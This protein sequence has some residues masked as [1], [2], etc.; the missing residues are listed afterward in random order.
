MH[1]E[2]LGGPFKPSPLT[3]GEYICLETAVSSNIFLALKRVKSE[4]RIIV[5]YLTVLDSFPINNVEFT[6]PSMT[7][8]SSAI[9]DA[10]HLRGEIKEN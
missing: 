5:T 1:G 10:Q 3:L 9:V 7:I 2:R 4:E 6:K 8:I